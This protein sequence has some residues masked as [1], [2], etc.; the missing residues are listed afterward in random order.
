MSIFLEEFDQWENLVGI[1]P[2][3]SEKYVFQLYDASIIIPVI[4]ITSREN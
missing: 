4:R 1:S 3:N 2:F